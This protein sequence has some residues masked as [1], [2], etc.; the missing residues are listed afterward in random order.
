MQP[1]IIEDSLSIPPGTTDNVIKL[2][3]ALERYLRCPFNGHGKLWAV[4]GATGLRIGLD[5]GSHNVV[6]DSD[7]RVSTGIQDPFDLVSDGWWPDEGHQLT[8]KAINS[9]N[10]PIV[11]E[12]RILLEAAPDGIPQPADKHVFQRQVTL[13]DSPDAVQLLDGTRYEQMPIPA[14]CSFFM[15]SSVDG[16]KREVYVSN[17]NIAPPSNV[18]ASNRIPQDPLDLSVSRIEAAPH[19][20]IELQAKYNPGDSSTAVVFFKQV[21]QDLVR[22]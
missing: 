16:V 9:T 19:K 14:F 12:Y 6:H 8:L 22:Q 15:T 4:R 5:Y 1:I 21:V 2:N 10:A 13:T 17:E 3:P 18:P 7:I 11:L 20:K